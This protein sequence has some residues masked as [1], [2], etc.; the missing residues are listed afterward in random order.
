MNKIV[1]FL[2]RINGISFPIGG[3]SWNP[4]EDEEK[5]IF[6]LFVELSNRRIIKYNHGLLN[7]QASISSLSRIRDELSQTIKGLPTDSKIIPNL[8]NVRNLVSEFQTFIE[9]E[10]DFDSNGNI[11]LSEE[12]IIALKE[13]RDLINANFKF[14]NDR[15]KFLGFNNSEIL[16]LD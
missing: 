15:P 4:K 6:N 13:F 10:A 16:K 14:T 7:K 2:K 11:I 9:N 12:I 3:I 1:K 5:T 8:L